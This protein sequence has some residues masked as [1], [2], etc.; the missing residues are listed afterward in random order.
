MRARRLALALFVIGTG[1]GSAW[2]IRWMWGHWPREM[3]LFG[4]FLLGLFVMS[5]CCI[6]AR[7]DAAAERAFRRW[8]ASR[9]VEPVIGEDVPARW[10]GET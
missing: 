5:L 2:V 7:A 8:Q 6:A 10:P 9:R 3:V 1:V 4:A